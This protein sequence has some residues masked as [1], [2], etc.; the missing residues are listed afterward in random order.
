MVNIMQLGMHKTQSTLPQ[1]HS[2]CILSSHRK[3]QLHCD[4]SNMLSMPLTKV[5]KCYLHNM[6]THCLITES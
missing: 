3:A 2:R 6:Q 4:S 1:I 5:C